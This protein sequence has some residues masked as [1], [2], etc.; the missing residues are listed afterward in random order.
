MPEA[1][2][3]DP[4]RGNDEAD[5]DLVAAARRDPHAFAPLYRRY[6]DAVYRYCFRRLGRREDAED[7]TAQIFAQALAGLPRLGASPFRAWLF[8]IAHNVVADLHRAQRPTSPLTAVDTREDP[9]PTPEHA[10]LAAEDGRMI[11]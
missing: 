7:A 1:R 8:A 5:D 6:V 3:I 10:A 4:A 9:G 2:Q 11:R